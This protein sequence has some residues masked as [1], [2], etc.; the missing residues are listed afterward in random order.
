M[1]WITISVHPLKMGH[2]ALCQEVLDCEELIFRVASLYY[3][4]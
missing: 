4:F 1:M 2:K 3:F